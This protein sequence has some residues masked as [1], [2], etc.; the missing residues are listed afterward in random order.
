M[1][2][3]TTRNNARVES[4]IV[5]TGDYNCVFLMYLIVC[6]SYG[7]Q[8]SKEVSETDNLDCPDASDANHP[9][10]APKFCVRHS[11]IETTTTKTTL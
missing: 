3:A 6:C 10:K 2:E 11:I 4:V 5:L 1:M 9:D 7:R 8:C